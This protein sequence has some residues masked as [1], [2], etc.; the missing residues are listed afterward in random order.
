MSERKEGYWWV[1]RGGWQ[2]VYVDAT[3]AIW[4]FARDLPANP[5]SVV[6]WGPY[7][8]M[9]PNDPPEET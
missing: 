9:E 5:R 1:Q 7:I 4:R 8:G 3:G 2:I 6:E